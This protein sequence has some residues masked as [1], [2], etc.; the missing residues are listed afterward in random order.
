VSCVCVRVHF[1]S[2]ACD[3]RAS[4]NIGTYYRRRHRRVYVTHT[5]SHAQQHEM[6]ASL[7]NVAAH[8]ELALDLVV[9][10]GERKQLARVFWVSDDVCMY[11]C[12]CVY[13]CA[14]VTHA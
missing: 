1:G 10:D 7:Y 6:F 3:C 5:P 2:L 9:D 4:Y 8:F 13:A 11:G 14:R 12:M